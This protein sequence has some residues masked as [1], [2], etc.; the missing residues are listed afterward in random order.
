M[1][2]RGSDAINDWADGVGKQTAGAADLKKIFNADRIREI[3]DLCLPDSARRDYVNTSG[4]H[5]PTSKK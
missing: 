3:E 5:T 1:K 2:A 4:G